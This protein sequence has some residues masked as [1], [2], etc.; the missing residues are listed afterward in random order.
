MKERIIMDYDK[1][2]QD[3]S[4]LEKDM[5]K[6]STLFLGAISYLEKELARKIN[7]EGAVKVF[8]IANVKRERIGNT[9]STCEDKYQIGFNVSLTLNDET[10]KY[11]D[12][13]MHLM[14]TSKRECAREN[15]ELMYGETDRF[16][17]TTGNQ[18]GLDNLHNKI[19]MF[20][21][22][23]IKTKGNE[24]ALKNND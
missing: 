5:E 17:L 24:F 3:L 8:D 19:M 10:F 21:E 15:V 4:N 20:I 22:K 18:S 1:I 7:K 14:W 12:D 11:V 6:I 16:Y 13:S 2:M 23:K 9:P